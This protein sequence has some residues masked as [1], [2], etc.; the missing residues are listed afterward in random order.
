MK[1][2]SELFIFMYIIYCIIMLYLA[3]NGTWQ[4]LNLVYMTKVQELVQ[5]YVYMFDIFL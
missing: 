4:S 3:K 5:I 1:K 2:L